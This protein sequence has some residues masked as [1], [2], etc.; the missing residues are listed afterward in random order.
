[1]SV[2]VSACGQKRAALV[3]V[4]EEVFLIDGG[5][6]EEAKGERE[7]FL[8]PIFL[9]FPSSLKETSG[10]FHSLLLFL[11]LHFQLRERER[12]R[13]KRQG[14]R[15]M[16]ARRAKERGQEDKRLNHRASGDSSKLEGDSG[17]F[18][19]NRSI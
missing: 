18:D 4:N 16:M 13:E 6:G 19:R 1:M 11:S 9:F 14:R 8:L 10:F 5:G 7:K 3:R 12:E 15:M 17:H 2:S